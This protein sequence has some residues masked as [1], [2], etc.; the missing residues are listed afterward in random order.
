MTI[1]LVSW[2]LGVGISR[3]SELLAEDM[4]A[5]V[6]RT[7]VSHNELLQSFIDDVKQDVARSSHEISQNPATS[8][9]IE[10]QQ[11]SYLSGLMQKS[12]NALG[13]DFALV[14]D[15]DG[16]L[17]ASFPKDIDA[18]TMED[19]YRSLKGSESVQ[20]TGNG[21]GSGDAGQLGI[22][23]RYD[24]DF[25]E[26]L[27][28]GERGVAGEGGIVIASLTT[29]LDEFG[30]TVGACITG[31]LLNGYNK[32]L[33]QTYQVLGSTS[34]LYLGSIPI[35]QAGFG[36]DNRIDLKSLQLNSSILASIYEADKTISI[37]LPLAEKNYVT[38]FSPILSSRGEKIGAV[39]VGIPE[40]EIVEL[41]DTVHLLGNKT[42][43]RVQA[44]FFGI[45]ALS[46]LVLVVVSLAIAV[47]I[48][49]P[50]KG[51]TDMV[52]DIEE[53]GDF[54]KRIN[55][56]S[57]DEIG[58]L[59]QCF[60]SFIEK[61][62]MILQDIATSAETLS[63]ASENLSQLSGKMSQGASI[64]F[65]K[66]NT[67]AGAAEEMN[68]SIGTVAVTMEEAAANVSMVATAA[69]QMTASISEI[70]KNSEKAIAITRE[71]VSEAASASDKVDELGLAAQEIG[72][73]TETIAEISAQTNLLA[74]NATIEAARAGEAGKGFAVVASEIKAL[75]RQTAEA[76]EGVK[77]K[78]HGI[79][80]STQETV[81]QIDKISRVS[82]DVSDIVS[83]IASAVEEQSVT[84]TEIAG[85][86]TQ[87]SG[88]IQEITENVAQSSVVA[89]EIT[90]DIAEVNHSTDE[91]S[92]SSAKVNL[93]ARELSQLAEK[94]KEM[95]GRFTV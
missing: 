27:G 75:A 79:Q 13:T 8:I 47:S 26:R 31:K 39:G 56:T 65:S 68:T 22:V 58:V 91:I 40:D 5:R 1:G 12:C 85:N 36:L 7:L 76:T 50:I 66:S 42:R 37:V 86:V 67:V 73:V 61:L 24:T 16:K 53:S 2:Q 88:G 63:S 19:Y 38:A 59:A 43:K 15:I 74:L 77:I 10:S 18:V 25:L 70:A 51:L 21:T 64:M 9:N 17:Q 84:T 44:W 54:T 78:I 35:A 62:H 45:G 29:I 33:K 92:Q 32:F 3:Q 90:R 93:S 81:A 69:E 87:V 6:S 71:A 28:L 41:Q 48:V 14:Y 72:K 82:K 89:G 94:L 30:D 80:S 49:R 4:M 95:V 34:A 55:I 20:G 46:L 52:K 83:T 57:K 60:N 11:L 23:S